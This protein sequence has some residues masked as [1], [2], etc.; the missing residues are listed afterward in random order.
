MK[1]KKAKQF[2][3]TLIE[4]V[5]AIAIFSFITG[6]MT[7]NFAQTRQREALKQGAEKLASDIRLVQNMAMTGQLIENSLPIGGYGINFNL[8][9]TNSG[10]YLFAD[11]EQASLSGVCTPARNERFDRK[12]IPSPPACAS[13]GTGDDLEIPP[14][15]IQFREGVTISQIQVIEGQSSPSPEQIVDI[16]FLPPKPIPYIGFGI[17]TNQ[18]SPGRTVQIDL[19]QAGH[20]R[21]VTVVGATG[22]VSISNLSS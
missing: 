8:D 9:N 2:G 14:G 1:I 5:I 17:I 22:Q 12:V 20:T 6:I 4:L 7:W 13:D 19:T 10:Y 16:G 18:S 21:R 3:F 15:L 11:R